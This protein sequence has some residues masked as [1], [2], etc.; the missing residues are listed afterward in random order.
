MI[1]VSSVAV[2]SKG[3][4]YLS[5]YCNTLMVP[6]LLLLIIVVVDGKCRV[7][8]ERNDADVV[9]SEGNVRSSTTLVIEDVD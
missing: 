2:C 9:G 3:V 1:P 5:V 4:V 7:C 8:P 6:E